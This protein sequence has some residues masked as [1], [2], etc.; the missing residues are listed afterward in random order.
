MFPIEDLRLTFSLVDSRPLAELLAA[1]RKL[2]VFILNF[3]NLG[4]PNAPVGSDVTH[5]N[6]NVLTKGLLQHKD[7]LERL[8][9]SPRVRDSC[10]VPSYRH[11]R[12]PLGRIR[13]FR[14]FDA[15]RKLIV[16]LSAFGMP[17]GLLIRNTDH[18][19]CLLDM[20]PSGIQKLAID[21]D[22]SA[23]R[24][25]GRSVRKWLPKLIC[26]CSSCRELAKKLRR[27][28]CNHAYYL[29]TR[30]YHGDCSLGKQVD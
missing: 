10:F 21:I 30:N 28:R 17:P 24:W 3:Q 14:D 13:Y 12:P 25:E 23:Y 8:G 16:P 1:I 20:L 9:I 5:I 11:I 7:S 6:Y 22:D 4:R 18:D 2:R 29:R 15:L 26:T 27:V 19:L